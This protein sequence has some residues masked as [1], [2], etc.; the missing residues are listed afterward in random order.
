MI[1]QRRDTGPRT[2]GAQQLQRSE[3]VAGSRATLGLSSE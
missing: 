2:D 1:G 3:G